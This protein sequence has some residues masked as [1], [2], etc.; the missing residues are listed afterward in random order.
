MHGNRPG[1]ELEKVHITF[2]GRC[3]LECPFCLCR[4]AAYRKR[5]LTL[6]EWLEFI[7]E[8]SALNVF[9]IGIWGGEPF[10]L[11]DL[12]S[13]I[14]RI[15]AGRMRFHLITNGTCV[16]DALLRHIAETGRCDF[17][18]FSL[19][20]QEEDHD[21][22]RGSGVFQK[23]L[24]SIRRAQELGIKVRGNSVISRKN[25]RNALKFAEFLES[26]DLAGYRLNL[27][28]SRELELPPDYRPLTTKEMADMIAEFAPHFDRLPRLEPASPVKRYYHE[29]RNPRSDRDGYSFCSAPGTSLAIR[30]D[31]A[32]LPCGAAGEDILGFANRDRMD[33][34]R[35][36][37]LLRKFRT[38]LRRGS[39]RASA[40]CD[41]CEY[42]FYCRKY[43]P[44]VSGKRYCRRELAAELRAR[45]V[46]P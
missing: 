35:D 5:E 24:S 4:R 36:G 42:R 1:Y 11:P 45:G 38:R 29:L 31:G 6:D 9:Q 10:L 8:L 30:P 40:R 27:V 23:A 37:V 14:D 15:V 43:C 44:G 3:N 18:Q 25:R 32:I 20:G 19:D 39:E 22:I 41:G 21:A 7:D 34:I 12:R 26:L 17:I 16:D 13:I 2:S 28:N 46:L 33:E